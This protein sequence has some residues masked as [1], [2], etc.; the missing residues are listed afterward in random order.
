MRSQGVPIRAI[1]PI[2]VED[3]SAWCAE[4]EDPEEAR[5]AHAG[6]RR[7]AVAAGRNEPC[8][9][10]SGRKYKK[11]CGPAP[12]RPMHDPQGYKLGDGLRVAPP[13]RLSLHGQRIDHCLL[14][15]VSV[16]VKHQRSR[17]IGAVV[18]GSDTEPCSSELLFDPENTLAGATADMA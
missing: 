1:A 15:K 9:C 17:H 6:R 11:C 18:K 5:A 16:P 13:A 10:G 3:Y 14:T 4:H 7:G 12:G 8:W 2:V